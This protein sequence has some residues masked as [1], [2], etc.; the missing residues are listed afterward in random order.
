MTSSVCDGGSDTADC[1]QWRREKD[2]DGM[3]VFIYLVWIL[4]SPAVRQNRAELRERERDQSKAEF[5]V[6]SASLLLLFN[7]SSSLWP[8]PLTVF[9]LRRLYIVITFSSISYHRKFSLIITMQVLN[10]RKVKCSSNKKHARSNK[11]K[12]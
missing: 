8:K 12:L 7:F 1:R 6:Q 3:H 10:N 11:D 4:S 5:D 2:D 9:C